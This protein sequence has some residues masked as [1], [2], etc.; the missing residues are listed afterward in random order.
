M[1]RYIYGFEDG[2]MDHPASTNFN[3]LF[4]AFQ[5]FR[6]YI[7]LET[8]FRERKIMRPKTHCAICPEKL[9]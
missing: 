6:F 7:D 3:P 5:R 4:A 1:A 8:R 2:R 9:A